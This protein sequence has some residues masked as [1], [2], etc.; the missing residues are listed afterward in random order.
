MQLYTPKNCS[1]AKVIE[2]PKVELKRIDMCLC[3]EPRQVLSD[4]YNQAEEKPDI[5]INGGFFSMADGTTCF[6]YV[7]EGKEISENAKY[8]W[9]M[10]IVDEKNLQYGCLDNRTDWRDFISGYPNLIDNG[11]KIPINFAKEIDYRAR[12]SVLAYNKDSIFIVAIELPGMTFSQLQD[13]L[14]TLDVDYAINL[15]GGGSTKILHKGKSVTSTQYNRAVDNVISFYLKEDPSVFLYR[16]QLGAFSKKE[17]A[18]NLLMKIK[19]LPDAINVGYK[20]AYIR[21]INGLYKVQVGAFSKKNNAER[22]VADLK[23]LGFSSFITTT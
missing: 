19:E 22:V 1:Y 11:R 2:I 7:D 6:N 23:K 9:G 5:M 21:Y 4:F 10:G 14:L 12:R 3:K 17:N 18:Q 13:F 8:K 20:N 16:V 15:D